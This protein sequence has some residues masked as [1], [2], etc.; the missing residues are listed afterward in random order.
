MKANVKKNY[1]QRGDRLEQE[2]QPESQAF[3]QNVVEQSESEHEKASYQNASQISQRTRGEM[4]EKTN[5][6]KTYNPAEPDRHSSQIRCCHSVGLDLGV[7]MIKY[8]QPYCQTAEGRGE[9][10][11]NYK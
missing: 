9:D 4:R 7:R 6:E 10:K 8:I 2:F 1:Y 11:G 5:N 3:R